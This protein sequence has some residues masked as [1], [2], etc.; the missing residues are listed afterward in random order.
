VPERFLET[1]FFFAAGLL[2]HR[3]GSL[4]NDDWFIFR[5]KGAGGFASV[6][7]GDCIVDWKNGRHYDWLLPMDNPNIL[8]GL[9][10]WQMPLPARRRCVGGIIPCRHVCEGVL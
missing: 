7:V 6:C 2:Q 1:G 9:S 10:K 8:P 5:N 3:T 4:P